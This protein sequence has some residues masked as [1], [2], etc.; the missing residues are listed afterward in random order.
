MDAFPT[1]PPVRYSELRHQIR[2]GDIL[3]CAGSSPFSTLI[4]RATESVFSHVGFLLRLDAI[5]RIMIL[6]SV[7]SIG[8][9]AMPLS[10][11][12]CDYNA[13]NQGYP[14]KMLIARHAD[15][16]AENIAYLSQFATRLLGYPYNSREIID[17]AM[18]IGLGSVGIH[19]ASAENTA[20]RAFICSEYVAFCFHSVGIQIDYDPR[21][22][23][24]PA[25]FARCPRISPVGIIDPT[26]IPRYEKNLPFALLQKNRKKEIPA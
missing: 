3:L 17:I 6:E 5:D 11:Y 18:R 21:G 16:R 9:R 1:L 13:T 2:S 24:A 19:P 4:Q 23:I 15:F 22:F 10:N 26:A 7:E 8:V 20:R 14:G 12:V 25:D